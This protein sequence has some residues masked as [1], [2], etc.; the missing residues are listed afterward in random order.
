[1]AEAD[2]QYIFLEVNAMRWNVYNELAWTEHILTSPEAYEN[3]ALIYIKALKSRITVKKP[4][5]LHLGCG[6]GGYDFHFKK[7]F[8]ITGVDLSEGMLKLAGKT[9]PEINYIRGD[10]RTAD[11]KEKFDA[12]VIPDSVMYM[13]TLPDLRKAVKNASDRLKPGG[14]FL[15][16]A[17]TREEFRNN[18]FAYTG[19]KDNIHITVLE[20]N[21]IVSDSTYESAMIHLIRRAGKLTIHSEVHTLGL[22]PFDDWMKI[23]AECRLKMESVNMDHLYDQH[24]MNDGVYKL[25]IFMGVSIP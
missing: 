20:N 1:L 15:V 19:E 14:I 18:N 9:N 17:H 16:T 3:E 12:V 11:V 4:S 8:S 6:A 23:F 13:A 2:T 25:K 10:M 5:M 24:L 21:H 7:F 22:F